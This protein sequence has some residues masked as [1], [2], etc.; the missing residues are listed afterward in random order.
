MY[1]YINLWETI[2]VDLWESEHVY[3]LVYRYVC[4]CVCVDEWAL[5]Q[6]QKEQAKYTILLLW[7]PV[8]YVRLTSSR[9]T[10]KNSK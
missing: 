1:V 5:I 8:P 7:N 4:A 6:G 10:I 9:K 3:M 2:S